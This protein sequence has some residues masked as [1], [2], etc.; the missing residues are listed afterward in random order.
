MNWY[1][2]LP[3]VGTALAAG[4]LIGIERGWTL[5][6]APDGARVAG[7]RTFTLLGLLAGVAGAIAVRGYGFVAG[8]LVAAAAA[9]L[10][11]GYGRGLKANAQADATSA[12]AGFLT[13]ALGFT[14]GIGNPALAIAGAALVT[15]VLALRSETHTLMRRLEEADVKAL[16]RYAVIALAVL[17]FLP[18][19]TY[20][21]YD[22][23][24][25]RELWLVVILVTG[26]SFAGYA[27]NRVFGARH[28]TI[29]TALIGGA[30]SSTAV[31]YSFA[32]RL[33][34]G[35]GGSAENAG[36]ALATAVMYLRVTVLVAVLATSALI[37][38]AI[39]ILP[40]LI[41]GAAASLWLCRNA[42]RS[43]APAPP[44][45]P[46]ALIPALTFLL[47]V[48]VTAVAARWAEGRYGEEGIAV[49]ILIMGSM[50][51]DAAIVT[52]GG[53]DPGA[54]SPQLAAIALG[55]T[56]FV[57]MVVKIAVAL[58]YARGR[59]K[60]AALALGASLVALAASLAVAGSML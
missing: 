52:V 49:L 60:S 51:V 54:L 1:E 6:M 47:F 36:I 29:A 30:Y 15:L 21:P 32:Q 53:L 38:F 48:A 50:D 2:Q 45:N 58:A 9:T 35:E 13:L 7:I 40:P 44:G 10:A 11:I 5:R 25:L 34:S 37:P 8:A 57:N 23:W 18:N 42:A 12:V 39:L 19:G 14:A 28:G 43:D 59:A 22:A 27:A 4:L 3:W 33:G 24:N 56:V 17:P 55:G 16:A 41:V 20:G 26:F 31:T 46:I